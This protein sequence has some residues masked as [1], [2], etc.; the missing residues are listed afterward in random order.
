MVNFEHIGTGKASAKDTRSS[1][2]FPCS[3]ISMYTW[4]PINM[5]EFYG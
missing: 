4:A 1:T 3:Y 5:Y 2:S